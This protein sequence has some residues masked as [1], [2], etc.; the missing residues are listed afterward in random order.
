MLNFRISLLPDCVG[1]CDCVSRLLTAPWLWLLCPLLSS[2]VAR[3]CKTISD[4]H[5]KTRNQLDIFTTCFTDDDDSR[6]LCQHGTWTTNRRGTLQQL[7]MR[8][9]AVSIVLATSGVICYNVTRLIQTRPSPDN[10]QN[11][12]RIK[13]AINWECTRT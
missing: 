11:I 5:G 8:A 2:Q 7:S 4:C 3:V 6:T 9:R 10:H 1:C 13:S 12:M